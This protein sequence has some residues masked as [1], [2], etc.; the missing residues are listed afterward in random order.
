MFPMTTLQSWV[1][2][3]LLSSVVTLSFMVRYWR[4]MYYEL[5]STQLYLRKLEAKKRTLMD[6]VYRPSFHAE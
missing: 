5:Q 3:I 2:I 4:E 6:D 1:F